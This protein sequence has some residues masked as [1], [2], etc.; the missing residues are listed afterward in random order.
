MA[1]PWD[2][3]D[4]RTRLDEIFDGQT[5]GR[6]PRFDKSVFD[7]DVNVRSKI[8]QRAGFS[9]PDAGGK[10]YG[11]IRKDKKGRA[12]LEPLDMSKDIDEQVAAAQAGS[13]AQLSLPA[14]EVVGE[15]VKAG[16]PVYWDDV[17]ETV[18]EMFTPGTR[19]IE[20]P[21][22][23]PEVLKRLRDP[24]PGVSINPFTGEEPT[25][26]MVAI[27]G[28]SLKS[29]EEADIQDFIVQNYDI[30]NADAYGAWVSD[31]TGKPVVEISRRVES[32]EEAVGLG[33]AFDQ[34]GIFDTSMQTGDDG[35]HPTGGIDRLKETQGLHERSAYTTK[36][37]VRTPGDAQ[38][39][40]R[41]QFT[42][43]APG[44]LGGRI[45]TDEQLHILGD[46]LQ[47]KPLSA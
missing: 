35:Y 47:P 9:E 17:A 29:F 28:K 37:Y 30:L 11:V 41:N 21:S 18:P 20:D 27:D 8:Y 13:A 44:A 14:I 38:S 23:P 3:L 19:V 15:R 40:A 1:T 39:I 6:I 31:I 34:E 10:M 16:V 42:P 26:F 7:A 24:G 22:F 33:K 32:Y 45:M 4:E 5:K 46:S 2:L 25:G 12:R 43:G 36:N